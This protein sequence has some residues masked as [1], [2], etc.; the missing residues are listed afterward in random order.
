MHAQVDILKNGG[1]GVLPTDTL[2]G[3]VAS[4][5]NK[6]A[7]ER[8]YTLKGRAPA[9]P[10][11]IL[12]SSLTDLS[13]FTVTLSPTLQST[14]KKYWPGPTSIILPCAGEKFAY[15]HRGTHSLAFRLPKQEAL[16]KLLQE[17][18]PLIAPSANPE[19]LTPAKTI[20]EARAY[21]GERVDFYE[22][23]G[24]LTNPPSTLIRINENGE[25]EKLR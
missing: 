8:V 7:V 18:G 12:I 21:F 20:E 25:V 14:L 17:T 24:T 23:G 10:C 2:Y 1:I 15:L 6:E 11:I 5:R 22:D 13:V 16:I 9:K 19:G 4:A 3:V